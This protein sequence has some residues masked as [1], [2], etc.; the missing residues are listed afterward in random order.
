MDAEQGQQQEIRD[1]GSVGE[2]DGV[3]CF[4]QRVRVRQSTGTR[5]DVHVPFR[6]VHAALDCMSYLHCVVK[7]ACS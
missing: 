2:S 4:M 1:Q 5:F 6:N 7:Q 3:C